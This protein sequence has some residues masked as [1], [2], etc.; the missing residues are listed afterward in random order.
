MSELIDQINLSQLNRHLNTSLPPTLNY[1]P[2]RI[3]KII[4]AEEMTKGYNFEHKI[5]TDSFDFTL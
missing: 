5:F 1:F 3:G 4:A 2:N